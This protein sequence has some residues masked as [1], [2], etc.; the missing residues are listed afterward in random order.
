MKDVII[1][2]KGTQQTPDEEKNVVEFET[3]GKYSKE[4]GKTCIEYMESELTGMA[5]TK[6]S[7]ELTEEGATITR[8]GTVTSQMV[9]I[10]GEK[11][12]FM[13]TTPF[14]SL[15]IGLDTKTV[16]ADLGE[17]GGSL[18]IRYYLDTDSKLLS[19]NALEIQIREV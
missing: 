19:K 17:T 2:I 1:S 13:Y 12:Y 9:F 14:G 4:D 5:G 3:D 7:I 11:N 8:T 16:K 18:E 10:M 6:T 15:T